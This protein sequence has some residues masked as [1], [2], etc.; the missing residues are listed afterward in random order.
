MDNFAVSSMIPLNDEAKTISKAGRRKKKVSRTQ[1]V[2]DD[3]PNGV[4]FIGRPEQFTETF[5]Q[6]M[7]GKPKS[8]L[9]KADGATRNVS[10][11]RSESDKIIKAAG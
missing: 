10:P 11:Q 7:M 6:Q 1:Q 2:L 4:R 8:S 3:L 5:F 9:Q